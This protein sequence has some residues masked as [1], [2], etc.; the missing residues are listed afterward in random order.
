MPD[1]VEVEQ[2]GE[3]RRARLIETGEPVVIGDAE[4]MSKSKK[5]VVSP[6]EIA[7]AYG[8][9]AARLF[10]MSDS[11]PERDVQWTTGGIKGAWRLVNRIWEQFDAQPAGR[12]ARRRRAT[13]RARS[14]SAA[15]P[16]G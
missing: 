7:E 16:T 9:D 10:V 11:P 6:E 2:E 1:E 14:S 3:T 15:R 12:R 4:K 5:N 8:V 13:T